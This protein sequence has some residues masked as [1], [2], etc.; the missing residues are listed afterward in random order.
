MKIPFSPDI[1]PSGWL[2]SEHQLT[3]W[4]IATSSNPACVFS[5]VYFIAEA[6]IKSETCKVWADD[7]IIAV[8]L[9]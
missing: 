1:I 5:V 6:Y 8:G 7:A 4:S 2:G 9:L 3:N